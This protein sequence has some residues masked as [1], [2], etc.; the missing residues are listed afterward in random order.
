METFK[1]YEVIIP[2]IGSPPIYTAI[3]RYSTVLINTTNTATV[4]FS[5]EG[6][7]TCV[8]TGIAGSDNRVFTVIFK[9]E[10]ILFGGTEIHKLQ[11]NFLLFT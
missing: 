3:M 5:E 11:Y 10:A 8:A 2:V 7:Y 1:D 6:N 4:R 9:G